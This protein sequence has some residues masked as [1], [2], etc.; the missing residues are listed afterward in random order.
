MLRAALYAATLCCLLLA[1]ARAAPPTDD[2]LA[3]AKAHYARGKAHFERGDLESAR[4]EFA[5]SYRLSGRPDLLFNLA[6]VAERQ[7]NPAEAAAYLERYLEQRPG[8]RDAK[9]VRRHIE[10]LR[11]QAQRRAA[12]KPKAP[13]APPE[14]A[15]PP[16]VEV[17]LS[18]PVLVPVPPPRPERRLP[19]WPALALLGGGVA[20]VAIGA[21]LGGGAQATARE[22]ERRFDPDLDQRGRSLEAAG[23]TFDVLGGLCLATGA[24]WTGLWLYRR[25]SERR[26]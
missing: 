6:V 16:R 26:M 24:V 8:A 13:A 14:Q 20:L 2:E 22:V 12:E 7:D 11:E 9:A 21:G 23:I 19:P 5:E 1:P 4:A 17:P 3:Q 10:R 15:P 18:R 25:P